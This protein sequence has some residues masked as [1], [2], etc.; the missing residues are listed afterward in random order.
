MEKPQEAS[1]HIPTPMGFKKNK[2]AYRNKHHHGLNPFG[3]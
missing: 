2:K 3:M 1:E